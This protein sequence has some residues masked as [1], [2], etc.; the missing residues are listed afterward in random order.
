MTRKFDPMKFN[1]FAKILKKATTVFYA[2]SI[3]MLFIVVII[4]I[5]CV[6]LPEAYF[7]THYFKSSNFAFEIS[8]ILRYRISESFL[9]SDTSFRN[10][11][12]T[13][14][15]AGSIYA[16]SL[17]GIFKLLKNLLISVVN[18]VP[19][20]HDNPKAIMNISYIIIAGAFIFPALNSMVSMSMLNT[21]QLN[22]FDV[23]YSIDLFLL[24]T[25]ALLF[26][27]SGIFEYGCYLQNEYD[28]T[29]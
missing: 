1:K 14:A 5:L 8:G 2:L 21:F 29:I 27:L 13:I 4:G 12:L 7:S 24:M 11:F 26:I 6:T 22:D 10:I 20:H 17:I 19:F 18:G 23:Y 3:I 28:D 25:G 9:S 15:G 16:I